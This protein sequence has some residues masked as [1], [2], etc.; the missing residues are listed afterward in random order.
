MTEYYTDIIGLRAIEQTATRAIFATAQGQEAIVLEQAPES[1]LSAL[2]FQLAPTVDLTALAKNLSA[3]G[4]RAQSAS[5]LTPGIRRALRIVDP[6][7]TTIDLFSEYTFADRDRRLHG[8]MPRKLGH[9]A[10][11]TP[12][13]RRLVAFYTDQLGFRVS[14]WRPETAYFLRCN[15][16]HH[17]INFFADDASKL[18]HIAF[19]LRDWS[20]LHRA[21]DFLAQNGRVLEWGPSRHIVGH[22]IACYHRDPDGSLVELY[23]ELDQMKDEELGYFDPRPWHEDVPQRP[24]AWAANTSTNYW[25]VHQIRAEKRG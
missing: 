20:E 4:I 11:V 5:D 18:H 16:D 9:V 3:A 12:E 24:K 15:S 17:A 19:E 21:C 10:F 6:K 7:G 8:L 22:N 1:G 23:T 14:D 2:S 25:G 13:L